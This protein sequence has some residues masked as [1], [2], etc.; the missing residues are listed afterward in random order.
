MADGMLEAALLIRYE[1]V[2]RPEELRWA[3]WIK[4]QE[5]KIQSSFEQL[6]REAEI[7]PGST[8]G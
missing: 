2:Q 6:E 1:T 5:A 7:S 8:P 4:G 3:D